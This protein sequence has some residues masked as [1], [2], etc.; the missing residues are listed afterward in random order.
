MTTCEGRSLGE[1]KGD[2]TL[3]ACLDTDQLD[4]WRMEIKT[5]FRKAVPS[6]TRQQD[7]K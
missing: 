6:D 2:I 7:E 4:L 3:L 5:Q 1:F